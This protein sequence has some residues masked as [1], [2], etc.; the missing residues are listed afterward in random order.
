MSK[1]QPKLIAAGDN[2]L[3]VYL[4]KGLMTAG[5][6]ALN[7]AVQWKR[8]GYDAR[9]IGAVGDDLGGEI[10]LDRIAASGID[11][12]D[13]E[14]RPG[15]TAVTLIR[16][17]GGERTFLLEALGVG[18]HY[19][20]ELLRYQALAEA[21]W[22]HLGTH[23]NPDLVRR[24]VADGVA[25]SVDISTA[26]DELPLEGVPLVFASA[27]GQS[28]EALIGELR[29]KGMRQ[30]VVTGGRQGAW[31]D[32]GSRL[33]HADARHVDAVD[34]CGAG[35]SFIAT[36][37]E[38]LY[39]RGCAPPEAMRSAAAAAALT[40]LHLGG[41]PQE[42]APIPEALLRKYRDY[43]KMPGQTLA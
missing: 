31:F 6:N 35:D 29:R 9:Y 25:F 36:L 33:W 30:L 40:C 20:P 17:D 34:T 38:G 11:A 7:V 26:H 19:H 16:D 39:F 18:E 13:V 27:S 12:D 2:C 43:Q 3:D 10:I 21:D 14:R 32:D 37:I 42:P 5:G 28:G 41:F 23:S 24:L 22:V 1:Q 15:D 4:S 8:D